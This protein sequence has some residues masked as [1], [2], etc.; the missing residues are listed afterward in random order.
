MQITEGSG[1]KLH[2]FDRVVGANTVHD[3]IVVVGAP[4]L[5]AYSV[6][7]NAL[8]IAGND[9]LLVLFAGAS[10]KLRVY[11]IRVQQAAIASAG[12]LLVFGISRTTSAGT[13]GTVLTPHPHETTDAASASAISKPTGGAALGVEIGRRFAPLLSTYPMGTF[14]EWVAVDGV[15]PI[16]IPAGTANGLAVV[17]LGTPAGTPTVNVE[18][19]FSAA[20]F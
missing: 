20:N 7:A 13:G 3:E 18:I 5:A 8:T 16:V 4:Y 1:K 14:T 15:K 2:T 6:V 17:A 9:K 12:D 19:V 10:E 11:R